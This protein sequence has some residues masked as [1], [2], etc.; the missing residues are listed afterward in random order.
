MTLFALPAC[1]GLIGDVHAEDDLLAAALE[2]IKRKGV[3][4]VLC[5]GDVA[6]GLGSVGRCCELLRQRSV[7]T[8]RGNHERWLL[9][10][11]M[12]DL[13]DANRP[14]KRFRSK[15]GSTCRTWSRRESFP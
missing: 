4:A 12:R 2:H 9:T 10:G 7:Q 3:D 14:A 8:V 15:R 1:M 11:V 5:T 6:D 13:P